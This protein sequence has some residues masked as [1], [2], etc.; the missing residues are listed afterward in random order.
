MYDGRDMTLRYFITASVLAHAALLAAWPLHLP[1]PGGGETTLHVA[2]VDAPDPSSAARQ[3]AI[4]HKTV[5][6]EPEAPGH[7]TVAVKPADTQPRR[8][9]PA[10]RPMRGVAYKSVLRSEST[11]QTA[12]PA[13][14]QQAHH[15]PV[16][17]QS[18]AEQL[19]A[20]DP[21]Q[22]HTAA[23]SK[24]REGNVVSRLRANLHQR[25]HA[26]FDY[27][28]IAR[29][30]GWQGLVTLGLRVEP[31]GTLTH[32]RVINTSGYAILDQASLRT[33]RGIARVP[34]AADW[35]GGRHVDLVLPVEYRLTEGG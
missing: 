18:Q 8:H 20:A 33:L 10:Q 29:V 26:R 7:V 12:A 27:P 1:A 2:L 17:Q 35:L 22:S 15:V 11:R 16:I 13:T 14:P 28:L 19:A 3:S 4:A 21:P 9:A 32:L 31:D 25:I 5:N 6:T 30:K 34:P 24:V 23:A